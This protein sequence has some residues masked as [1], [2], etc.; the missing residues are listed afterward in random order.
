[1]PEAEDAMTDSVKTD[2]PEG[3]DGRRGGGEAAADKEI[4]ADSARIAATH[5]S[6]VL[7]LAL[8]GVRPGYIRQFVIPHQISQSGTGCRC[9][10]RP[11][12]VVFA[13]IVVL[14]AGACRESGTVD[15]GVG[16]ASTLTGVTCS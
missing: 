12:G 7:K 14:P 10:R 1:M 5:V 11:D 9:R 6:V 8:L 3:H 4:L 16:A 15:A 13:Q 2:R